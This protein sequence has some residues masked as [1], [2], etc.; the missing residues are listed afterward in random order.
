MLY[1]TAGQFKTS[2]AADHALFP[3]RQ[4]AWL[5]GVILRLRLRDLPA[6]RQRV[7]LQGAAHPGADL[8]AGRARPQHPHR[9]CRAALARHRRLH[10]RRRL[11]LLQADQHLSRAQSDRRDLPL[12]L[13]FGRRR[14]RLR[15]AV[16]AHQGFLPRHRDACRAVLSRLAVREMGMA[17]QLQFVGRDPGADGIHIRD[18]RFRPERRV[19]RAVLSSCS[20]S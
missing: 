13:L 8:F 2:Y 17:L 1:R 11:C 15:P 16:A 7:H 10:G 9:L 5:L 6:H 12:G 3:V 14:R 19:D 18:S 20:A 4:D